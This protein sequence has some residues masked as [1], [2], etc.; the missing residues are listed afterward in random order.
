MPTFE[1]VC[2]RGHTTEKTVS[3]EKAPGPKAIRCNNRTR[4]FGRGAA[5]HYCGLQ[6]NR[7]NVYKVA[8]SGDLPTRGSF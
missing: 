4:Q 5:G 3:F 6:A 7:I 8:V 1:Y 2:P